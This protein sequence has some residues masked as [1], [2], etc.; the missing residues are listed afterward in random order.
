MAK[1]TFLALI[2]SVLLFQ[3]CS[4]EGW[5]EE[6][7]EKIL[8]KCTEDK[9]ECDCYLEVTMEYFKNPEDYNLKAEK[10][11]NYQKDLKDKC[12]VV[13]WKDE[14][15]IPLYEKCN[16]EEYDCDCAIGK[17]VDGFK[18]KKAFEAALKKNPDLLKELFTECKIVRD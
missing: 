13:A 7:K 1:V 6:R 14:E 3:S 11:L 9:Y 16:S 5:T 10:D 17:I 8:S 15:F 2:V 12:M 4:D 18:G